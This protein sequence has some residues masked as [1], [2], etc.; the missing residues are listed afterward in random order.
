M[1]RIPTLLC[2]LIFL[3][4]CTP[5]PTST[6][7][8]APS[9]TAQPSATATHTPQPS[10]TQNNILI[11]S[12]STTEPNQTETF[13]AIP[14]PTLASTVTLI[15]SKSQ[16]V[17][18]IREMYATNGGCEL[19]CFWGITPGQDVNF[20]LER[21]SPYIEDYSGKG[22]D[23]FNIKI[24]PPKDINLYSREE[25]E[26]YIRIQD[27]LVKTVAGDADYIIHFRIKIYVQR[28]VAW[29][30]QMKSGW[31]SI[32]KW[33]LFHGIELH[34]FIRTREFVWDGWDLYN[35]LPYQKTE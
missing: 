26:I 15:P 5:A 29:D 4:A 23:G 3:A 19:P 32:R 31:K 8:P 1:K 2:F 13:S 27:N 25:W 11:N 21:F 34:C 22:D 18:F 6:P 17:E 16:E 12:T 20:V 30:H 28:L 10:P 33:I 7:T 14:I 24:D 35:T 9:T